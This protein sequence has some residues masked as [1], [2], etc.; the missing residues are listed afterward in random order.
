MRHHV[1][2]LHLELSSRNNLHIHQFFCNLSTIDETTNMSIPRIP[3]RLL[4]IPPSMRSLI[5]TRS[6]STASTSAVTQH[7][8][9]V[10]QPSLWTS[11]VPKPLRR[12]PKSALDHQKPHWFRTF[13][14][15][16][17]TPILLL[18]L[19]VGSQA[20][21][22]LT[23]KNE[24][25]AYSRRTEAKIGVLR[26][27]IQRVQRGED[28]DVEGVLGTGDAAKEEEWFDGMFI[29]SALLRY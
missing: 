24:M 5:Y 10:A 3:L 27:V 9:R 23:L 12:T 11:M 21:Q 22:M 7:L 18:S 15:N 4:Q 2:G 6:S 1:T 28:V 25:F 14:S 29:L 8:P 20:I 13:W 26:D 17:V 16:P 19:L